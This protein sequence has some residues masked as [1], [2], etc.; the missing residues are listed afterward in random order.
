M[1]ES[2]TLEEILEYKLEMLGMIPSIGARIEEFRQQIATLPPPLSFTS[3]LRQ[4]GLNIIA[5]VKKASPTK[6]IFREDF[7]P[8]EIAGVYEQN[9]ASAISVLTESNYFMGS[10]KDLADVKENTGLPVL[11]KDFIV[12]HFQIF[13]A[14]AAGADAVLLI[15]AAIDELFLKELMM[16]SHS[17]GMPCLVEVHT[18]TDL[19]LAMKVE[20]KLI[21]INNRDLN[22]FQADLATTERLMKKIPEGKVTVSMSGISTPD[23]VRRAAGAGVNAVLVGEA[24]MKA[25][26][27][28]ARLRELKGA[29]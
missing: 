16:T 13:E 3:A 1:R 19:E 26:D 25:P 18:E 10:I 12:D 23:D 7:N 11:R 27:M 22:T 5:E 29:V 8:A 4:P 17:L 9:G 24:L 6:G 20:A 28:G 14:R 21:G 15:A 2:V